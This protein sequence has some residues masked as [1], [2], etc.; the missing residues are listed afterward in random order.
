M[1]EHELAKL[2]RK[3]RLADYNIKLMR[4]SLYSFFIVILGVIIWG[5]ELFI[6][7]DYK[8]TWEMSEIINSINMW[9]LMGAFIFN[10]LIALIG[11]IGYI[12][13][14][15]FLK[16]YDVLNQRELNN[17]EGNSVLYHASILS[18][19]DIA[20]GLTAAER[21]E[22][23]NK[24]LRI[25][26]KSIEELINETGAKKANKF[27]VSL[28]Y[29]ITTILMIILIGANIVDGVYSKNHII[30]SRDTSINLIKQAY[31][32]NEKIQ[33]NENEITESFRVIYN[34]IDMVFYLDEN[35]K[36]DNIHYSVRFDN[37]EL[38]N[39]L[40]DKFENELRYL[41]NNTK[42]FST[43]FTNEK[44]TK[45]ELDL[46]DDLK[47]KFEIMREVDKYSEEKII[48]VEGEEIKI[49]YEIEYTDYSKNNINDGDLR[50]TCFIS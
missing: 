5:I 48:V 12:F 20:K 15:L 7:D 11:L 30:T 50:F 46:T 34:N 14:M 41:Q 17:I 43:V 39:I 9:S 23:G 24:V 33:F 21:V 10:A 6:F 4:S 3:V 26:E 36:E 25:S 19:N 32:G 40:V 38:D 27:I 16:K 45:V 2:K 22:E 8:V 29:I 35:G 18:N 1:N 31:Q 37:E 44:V 47:N 13:T 49:K 42:E 28:P